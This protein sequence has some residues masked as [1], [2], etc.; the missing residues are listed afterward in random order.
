VS[1]FGLV[2]LLLALFTIAIY[3]IRQDSESGSPIGIAL[4]IVGLGFALV[5]TE[6]RI[7]G[8]YVAASAS[9]YTTFDLLT[10]IGIYLGLLRSSRPVPLFG[11]AGGRRMTLLA[12]WAIAGVICIQIPFG[13]HNGIQAAQHRNVSELEDV[14]ILR[15]IDH[16]S[17]T[18]ILQVYPFGGTESFILDQVK[19]AE[20]Y[21]LSVFADG[22]RAKR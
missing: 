8:G 7:Y 18:Q 11:R 1:L 14:R 15:N 13:L 21:H 19:I 6:G 20:K 10:P 9:R 4:I 17:F 22:D 2:I 5:V 16:A 3:G 12:R